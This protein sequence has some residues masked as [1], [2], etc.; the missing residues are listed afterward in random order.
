M[1][2]KTETLAHM[3]TVVGIMW[4]DAQEASDG[5]K[6]EVA[7]KIWRDTQAY[8]ESWVEQDRAEQR[9]LTLEELR[10]RTDGHYWDSLE[11]EKDSV[12]QHV[13]ALID[14]MV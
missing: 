9:R 13:H 7:M 3:L 6:H 8:A 2:K 12:T 11:L 10:K 1:T 4:E 14:S 5:D